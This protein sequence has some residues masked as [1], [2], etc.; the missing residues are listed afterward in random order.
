ML[1]VFSFHC[2]SVIHST[3]KKGSKRSSMFQWETEKRKKE[4][5]GMKWSM[6]KEKAKQRQWNDRL[7]Q[8]EN[9]HL[10]TSLRVC[11]TWYPLIDFCDCRSSRLTQS[12]DKQ[13]P[14]TSPPLLCFHD[15]WFSLL[16]RWHSFLLLF[17][18]VDLRAGIYNE[19]IDDYRETCQI[20]HEEWGL[21]QK[22][23]KGKTAYSC[24]QSHVRKFDDVSSLFLFEKVVLVTV[25]RATSDGN[26]DNVSEH[27]M[28]FVFLQ[29]RET[30]K[31][32]Q[33]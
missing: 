11:R 30:S 32:V 27:V 1:A 12:Q 8:F 5:G 25:S 2:C 3:E 20:N 23:R 19:Q 31:V 18:V 24:V 26:A 29:T 10:Y 7:K 21:L 33:N 17:F 14:L 15:D 28:W 9:W 13:N 6:P 22:G 16:C 4:A